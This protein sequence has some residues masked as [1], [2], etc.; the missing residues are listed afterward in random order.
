MAP[1]IE[2]DGTR[3]I[4]LQVG[5][6]GLQQLSAVDW[7]ERVLDAG[8]GLTDFTQTAALINRLDLV[9]TVDTAVAHLAGAL[10]SD[11]W[12][13]LSH[14]PDWRWQLQRS[15]SPWY[16]TM[17]LFRQRD[18]GDWPGVIREVTA[19]LSKVVENRLS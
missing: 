4:S 12:T 16:P 3:F 11:V 14:T 17:R 10:G 7:S 8:S 19:E 2:T 13:L 15:D 6:A 18:W 9:I 5:A 1:L